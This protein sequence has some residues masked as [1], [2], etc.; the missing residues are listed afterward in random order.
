MGGKNQRIPPLPLPTVTVVPL[1]YY[2]TVTKQLKDKGLFGQKT[3]EF[4]QIKPSGI[5]NISI[6]ICK[7]MIQHFHLCTNCLARKALHGKIMRVKQ[8]VIQRYA[9][10]LGEVFNGRNWTK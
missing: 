2:A 7:Q 3:P 10:L 4:L 6:L 1:V 9:H 8:R 5:S